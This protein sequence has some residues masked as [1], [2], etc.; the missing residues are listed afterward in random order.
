[1]KCLKE[2]LAVAATFTGS[3]TT[4]CQLVAA[5]DSR[6]RLKS[7]AV[8]APTVLASARDRCVSV[9]TSEGPSLDDPYVDGFEVSKRACPLRW[10]DTMRSAP[11]NVYPSSR[12]VPARPGR[13]EC[14]RR[15]RLVAERD[16]HCNRSKL[17]ILSAWL[18]S[19]LYLTMFWIM[20]W[21]SRIGSDGLDLF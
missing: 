18:L 9:I 16:A 10:R 21:S 14:S 5:S 13:H 6:N 12:P 3:K 17:F 20:W 7:K 15:S 1:M 19:Y 8:L 4:G 11:T 2:P